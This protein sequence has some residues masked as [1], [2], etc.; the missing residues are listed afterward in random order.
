MCFVS[1]LDIKYNFQ[2]IILV[3]CSLRVSP[4]RHLEQ[5]LLPS[6]GRDKNEHKRLFIKTS[7]PVY[8]L[9][10]LKRNNKHGVPEALKRHESGKASAR[11]ACGRTVDD[12]QGCL[13][14]HSAPLNRTV[15]PLSPS[16][17]SLSLSPGQ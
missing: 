14:E 16:S 7:K 2:K 1:K 3:E 4:E 6:P 12:T 5:T 10:V 11:S 8:S 9:I 13:F 17:V 15:E